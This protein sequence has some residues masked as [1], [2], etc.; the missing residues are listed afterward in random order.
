MIAA[1]YWII[2]GAAAL[3]L[4][5]EYREEFREQDAKP[6]LLQAEADQ[7]HWDVVF[8]RIEGRKP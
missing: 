2:M 3:Y 7:R 5:R 4:V 1:L 8:A 6:R